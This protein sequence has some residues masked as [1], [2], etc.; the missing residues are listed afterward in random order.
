MGPPRRNPSHISPQKT[1][2]NVNTEPPLSPVAHQPSA[3]PAKQPNLGMTPAS[4]YQHNL[5]V[6]RRRDPSIVSIFD[7]FSHVCLYHHNGTKWEKQ[8][9]EGSMFL[10]ER[11]SYPPYGFYIL[12]RMGMDDHIQRLY[13]EDNIGAHGSYLIIRS[14]PEFTDRRLALARA[15]HPNGTPHKFS[16]VYAVPNVDKLTAAEKGESNTIGLWMFATDSREPLIDIFTRLHSYIKKNQPYPQEFRY[17]PDRP[18]PSTPASTAAI[19]AAISAADRPAVITANGTS[20]KQTLHHSHATIPRSSSRPTEHA[21]QGHTQARQRSQSC[22]NGAGGPSE[23]DK[24]FAKIDHPVPS[25]TS[26]STSTM[27]QSQ[28]PSSTSKMTVESLFAALGGGELMKTADHGTTTTSASAS[29]TSASLSTFPSSS[30]STTG[31][32][33]LDSIF[34]SANSATQPPPNAIS[35]LPIRSPVP[36][37]TNPPPHPHPHPHPHPQVL[38]QDVISTLLGLPPSRSASAASTAYSRSSGAQSHPSSREGDNEHEG[39]RGGS[40]GYSESS[41]VLD[42]EDDG[43]GEVQVHAP[44]VVN[45]RGHGHGHGHGLGYGN[46]NGNGRGQGRGRMNGD[47]TPRAPAN[48]FITPRFVAATSSNANAAATISQPSH[49]HTQAQ[50]R[51]QTLPVRPLVPFQPDSELWPYPPPGEGEHEG[52]AEGEREGEGEE[53]ILELDFADMSALSD[54]DLFSRAR[55]VRRNGRGENGV[56]VGGADGGERHRESGKGKGRKKGRKEREAMEREAIERSWDVPP[57]R[58]QAGRFD[59]EREEQEGHGEGLPSTASPSPSSSPVVSK[60]QVNGVAS[61]VNMEKHHY[62]HQQG[63]VVPEAVRE[64]LI[65]AVSGRGLGAQGLE[66]NEFVR[67]VLTLIHTDKA[68]VDTLFHEYTSRV[69]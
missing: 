50:T 22:T 51:T 28:L 49:S 69:G 33:L 38:N 13:P 41:T 68:F 27:A 67:E 46:G 19:A 23:L 16:D 15:S 58:P 26:T 63:G 9:Y 44:A 17:G 6:L 62:H 52:E 1:S 32:P 54:P 47:V 14:Y 40:D 43:E 66:R 3:V 5:K 37:T 61:K 18:P 10:Y 21:G 36:S 35:T 34:A 64:S 4:R 29:T 25:S 65:A 39:G 8:G 42:P 45:G 56:V 20:Q 55:A 11:E 48:G 24:L 31:L 59:R 57:P 60:P 53:E 12:N 2:S 7:Q 30:P